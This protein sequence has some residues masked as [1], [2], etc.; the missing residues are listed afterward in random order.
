MVVSRVDWSAALLAKVGM[1]VQDSLFY[2][3]AGPAVAHA[4]GNYNEGSGNYYAAYS[5]WQPGFKA[6]VGA[7][8][9]VG[10]NVSVRAQYSALTIADRTAYGAPNAYGNNTG[11]TIWTN[12][13]SVATI[14]AAWHF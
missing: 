6:G 3:E 7:E 5:N 12:T 2:V 1:A 4:S 11:R 14:G 10:R 8:F 9:M 13:Q